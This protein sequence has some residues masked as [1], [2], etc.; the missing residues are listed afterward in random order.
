M[1]TSFHSVRKHLIIALSVLGM[2][3]ASLTV[4]AQQEPASAPA[5][6]SNPKAIQDGPR[7]RHC[8]NPANAWPNIRRA[9]M[10]S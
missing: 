4:H 7:H 2:G 10:T 5:A 3:A 9:C 6:S 8:G 1:N